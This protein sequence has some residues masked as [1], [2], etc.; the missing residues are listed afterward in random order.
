VQIFKPFFIQRI[1]NT[2][3]LQLFYRKRI[4]KQLTK[5]VLKEPKVY[6]RG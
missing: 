1:Q 4:K 2:A 5:Q 3:T 6:L